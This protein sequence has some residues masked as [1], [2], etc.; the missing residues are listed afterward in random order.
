MEEYLGG[1]AAIIIA[2]FFRA[3]SVII[4]VVISESLHETDRIK[5][6]ISSK[7]KNP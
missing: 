6:V 5:N 3:I 4:L 7:A 2:Q 1:A